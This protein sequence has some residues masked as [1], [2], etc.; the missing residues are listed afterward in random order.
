MMVNMV[1]V[2]AMVWLHLPLKAP[3]YPDPKSDIGCHTFTYALL[4][5][6]GIGNLVAFSR[7][8]FC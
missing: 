1:A 4:P 5:H 3:R 7:R 6:V 2:F 8:H